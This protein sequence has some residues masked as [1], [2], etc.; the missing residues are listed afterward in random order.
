[1]CR[2]CKNPIS[3]CDIEQTN[4]ENRR[5]ISKAQVFS[6]TKG[7]LGVLKKK[8]NYKNDL[9]Q[10]RCNQLLTQIKVCSIFFSCNL[11][12]KVIKVKTKWELL[13]YFINRKKYQVQSQ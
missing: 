4:C 1:M 2:A 5:K 13:Q 9:H 7:G 12:F 8:H 3:K 6:T 11:W 10:E